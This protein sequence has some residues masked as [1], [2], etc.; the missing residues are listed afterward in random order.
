MVFLLISH[1]IH[2][3]MTTWIVFGNPKWHNLNTNRSINIKPCLA[4]SPLITFITSYPFWSLTIFPD[5]WQ[6][7]VYWRYLYNKNS[8]L[9]YTFCTV[10]LQKPMVIIYH[11]NSSQRNTKIPICTWICPNDLKIML[12]WGPL[13]YLKTMLEEPNEISLLFPCQLKPILK[14]MLH[15]QKETKQFSWNI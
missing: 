2:L 4:S 12:S 13:T 11:I 14:I 5:H 1:K 10:K 3:Q 6:M 8:S 9:I 7:C 15:N